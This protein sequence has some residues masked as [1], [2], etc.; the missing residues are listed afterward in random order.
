MTGPGRSG[1]APG[2]SGGWAEPRAVGLEGAA[3]G[4]NDAPGPAER[5]GR[6]ERNQWGGAG[7]ESG[8]GAPPAA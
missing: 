4:R 1:A 5:S 8:G 6:P 7:A 3:P 2:R